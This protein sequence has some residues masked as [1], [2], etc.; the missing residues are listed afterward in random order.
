MI[1]RKKKEVV[2]LD[3]GT[4]TI[5]VAKFS[6]KKNKVYLDAY[7]VAPQPPEGIVKKNVVNIGLVVDP[8]KDLFRKNNINIKDVALSLS[9]EN[10]F[11]KKVVIPKNDLE[12]I[13]QILKGIVVDEFKLS[14]KDVKIDYKQISQEDDKICVFALAIKND[15]L[16]DYTGVLTEAGLSLKLVDV[17]VFS[18]ENMFRF[19]YEEEL[20]GSFAILNMGAHV[21]NAAIVSDGVLYDAYDLEGCGDE[22][23][24]EIQKRFGVSFEEAEVLKISANKD[25]F[26]DSTEFVTPLEVSEIIRNFNSDLTN[27][28]KEAILKLSSSKTISKIFVCG[29][30]SGNNEFILKLE[31]TFPNIS[32]KTINPFK[33]IILQN[34]HHNES[35]VEQRKAAG[36]VVG[37]GLRC[38]NE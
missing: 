38:L 21:I 5:K 30:A 2:A 1:F 6:K 15:F 19:N 34:D 35:F 13:N 23:T 20:K 36:V 17:D 12:N 14:K 4:R 3:I 10:V 7:D 33:N 24:Y 27:K 29:G 18:L 22:L 11:Y 8:I 26:R 37:L 25:T 9:G 16:C 28:I 32:V 31:K